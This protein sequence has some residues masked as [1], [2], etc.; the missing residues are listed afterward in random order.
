MDIGDIPELVGK[1][2]VG[3]FCGKVVIMLLWR[4]GWMQIQLV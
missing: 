3:R 2:V 4:V 1:T